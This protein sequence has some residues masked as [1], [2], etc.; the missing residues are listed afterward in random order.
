[1]SRTPKRIQ[2]R[3]TKG[4]R[5]PE[6]AVNVTRPGPYG[7]PFTGPDPAQAVASFRVYAVDRAA[8]EPKWLEPL[9]RRDLMCFCPLD[10][11][12]HADV[13]IELANPPVDQARERLE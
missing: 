9:R 2:R 13:L 3:R 4:W 8:R 5:K 6:G 11:P 7:N 12:C 10:A 1:M